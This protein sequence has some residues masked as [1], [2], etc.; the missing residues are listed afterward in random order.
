MPTLAIIKDLVVKEQYKLELPGPG[1]NAIIANFYDLFCDTREE[2]PVSMEVGAWG[3]AEFVRIIQRH[4]QR[5]AKYP[6][7]PPASA[8]ASMKVLRIFAPKPRQRWRRFFSRRVRRSDRVEI[9]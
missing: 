8:A 3:S 4:K 6:S 1:E 2:W 5:M 7:E 9:C